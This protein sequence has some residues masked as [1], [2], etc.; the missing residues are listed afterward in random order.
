MTISRRFGAALHLNINVL[1]HASWRFPTFFTIDVLPQPVTVQKLD[2]R[3]NVNHT[4]QA[5]NQLKDKI[6]RIRE[7]YRGG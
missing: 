7:E 4:C 6:L 2:L 1:T 3:L 5:T